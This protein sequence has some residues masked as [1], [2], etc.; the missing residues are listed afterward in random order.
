MLVGFFFQLR[1]G[2]VPVSLR[3]FLTLLEA[4]DADLADYSVEHFYY[5]SRSALVKDERHMDRFDR[6]FATVFEGLE[7]I[8][9]PF[10]HIPAEWLKNLGERMLSAEDQEKVK[11]LGGWQELLKTLQERM[12]EQD[13]RHAGGSKW[14]GTGGTSP[15]GAFGYNPMGVRIGQGSSRHRRAVKVWEKRDF[16][17]LDGQAELGTRNMKVALRKLRRLTRDGAADEFDLSGTIAATARKGWLDI[18]HQAAR[19]NQMK[20]LLL[21]DIG[22][23]MDDHVALADQLFTAAR[24]EFSHLEHVYFHNCLYERVWKNNSRRLSDPTLTQELLRT[25]GPDWRV[26]IV[27]D[28]S[29]SPYEISEP[30]GSVEHWNEEAGA[31]WMQRLSSHWERVVWLNPVPEEQWPWTPSIGLMNQLVGG[32]MVPLTIDG[33]ERAVRLLQ[34]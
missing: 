16:A 12:V 19:S 11:A 30:G 29:M 15:F 23:S 13:E 5:L 24:S 3:E 18:R 8:E 1:Q 28:A 9:D 2:G 10:D 32:R 34:H 25:Y 21:L 22:G 14:I 31:V 26:V 33:L 17:D 6:V 27:G 7:R 20:L 4:L